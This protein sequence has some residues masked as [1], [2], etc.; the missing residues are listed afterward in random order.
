MR[1]WRGVHDPLH[2]LQLP[3]EGPRLLCLR[4]LTPLTP[5]APGCSARGPTPAPRRP[6]QH[7]ALQHPAAEQRLP[8][9]AAPAAA[10]LCPIRGRPS[11]GR[12][13]ASRQQVLRHAAA[14]RRT[15]ACRTPRRYGT[16]PQPQQRQ[17]Q[18]GQQGPHPQQLGGSSQGRDRAWAWTWACRRWAPRSPE[19]LLQLQPADVPRGAQRTS[20]SRAPGPPRGPLGT[21][22]SHLSSPQAYALGP[23]AHPAG[24]PP[25]LQPRHGPAPTRPGRRRQGARATAPWAGPASAPDLHRC[26]TM[27][28]G[29]SMPPPGAAPQA[30]PSLGQTVRSQSFNDMMPRTW[31]GPQTGPVASLPP[32]RQANGG[33]AP[34]AA[35]P[36]GLHF[37]RARP[38]SGSGN[39]G[40]TARDGKGSQQAG[41][42]GAHPATPTQGAP[43]GHDEVALL[44][45]A[46]KGAGCPRSQQAPR[47]LPLGR[48]KRPQDITRRFESITEGLGPGWWRA[49]ASAAAGRGQGP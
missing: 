13:V 36:P 14:T 7:A 40:S 24:S 42:H 16:L 2:G 31:A 46:Q 5:P 21:R 30:A 3:S 19:L 47:A 15:P 11:R 49:R 17:G 44:C 35:G 45:P 38:S 6:Q 32:P 1:R 33:P 48:R 25:L 4:Q 28:P 10:A 29:L 43:A 12:A 8:F 34:A 39:P 20:S 22:P 18:R 23:S 41:S 37:P 9:P 26:S 27:P